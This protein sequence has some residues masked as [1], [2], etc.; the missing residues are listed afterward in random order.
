MSDTSDTT[1]GTNQEVYVVA[2][3]IKAMVKDA[4]FRSDSDL[5]S[6]LSL[7]VEE[8][9]KAA[10]NRAKENGRGTVRPYDL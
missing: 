8:L 9:L 7:K 1:T 10:M 4:G 5:V 2:S 3:K 6:A